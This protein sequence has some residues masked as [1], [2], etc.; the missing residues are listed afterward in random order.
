MMDEDRFGRLLREAARD[1]HAP[2]P[3][4]RERIWEGIQRRRRAPR[5]TALSRAFRANWFWLPAAA[6]LLLVGVLIGRETLRMDAE[7]QLG[8]MQRRFNE[9]GRGEVFAAAAVPFLSRADALLTR[10]RSGPRDTEDRVELRAWAGS[11]LAETRLLLDS[12][13]AEDAEMRL[14]FM[15][16]ELTLTRIHQASADDDAERRVIT[17]GMEDRGMLTRL[18]ARIPAGQSLAS[19]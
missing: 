16:L 3:A 2:P 6:L 1:H 9:A 17:E 13:A 7:R 10:Y 18:R 5:R 19:L 12:P 15:D 8:E 11:L 14:L 4:P